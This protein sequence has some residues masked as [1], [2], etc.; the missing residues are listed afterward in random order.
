[1][2]GTN[3]HSSATTSN[4]MVL[5]E[6]EGE[7]EDERKPPADGG[8]EEFVAPVI[9]NGKPADYQPPLPETGSTN[10]NIDDADVYSK[11]QSAETE[12]KHKD[13]DATH[14]NHF[15]YN[16]DEANLQEFASEYAKDD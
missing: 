7:M 16:Y 15:K 12:R 6:D 8:Y 10:P 13:D 2:R 3:A 4:A 9:W 1:M 14:Y 11:E 5:G